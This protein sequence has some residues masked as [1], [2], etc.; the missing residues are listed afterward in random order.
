MASSSAGSLLRSARLKEARPEG[1]CRQQLKAHALHT[2]QSGKLAKLL[3][4]KLFWGDIQISDVCE[5]AQAAT[6]DGLHY[7]ELDRLAGLGTGGVHAKNR[8]RD[9]ERGLAPMPL[10]S[11]LQPIKMPFQINER[12]V[13]EEAMLICEPHRLFVTLYHEMPHAF[14]ECML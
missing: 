6:E 5:L 1:G 9:L 12:L 11:T 14:R 10:E 13:V 3:C 8:T 4:M 2:K 7:P